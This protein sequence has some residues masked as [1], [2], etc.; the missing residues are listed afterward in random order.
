[1]RNIFYSPEE[2]GLEV[3]GCV[4]YSDGCYQFDYSCVWRDATGQLYYAEDS[5]CSCPSPFEDHALD[6]LEKVTPHEVAEK[7]QS[8]SSYGGEEERAS[9]EIAELIQRVMI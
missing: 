4:D 9:A 5:G 1:M 3:V 7:L 8:R 2:F 6:D